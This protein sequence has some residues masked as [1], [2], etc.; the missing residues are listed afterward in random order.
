MNADN[1][2]HHEI[3]IKLDLGSFTN[4]LKLIGF[5]GQIDHEEKQINSFFDSE[6]RQLSKAGWALRIRAENNR[7]LVTI[8]SIPSEKGL[9]VVR[10]EIEAEIPRGQAL[11]VINLRQDVLGLQVMPVEFIRGKVGETALSRLVLFENTRQKKVFRIGDYNYLLEIDKTEYNDGSVDYELELELQ[12]TA[13]LQVIESSLMKLF[14]S[15]DIPFVHQTLS[16]FHRALEKAN[17]Y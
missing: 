6:D 13:N 5:L 7:G 4:Y 15:L 17:I 8:K 9:A 14:A 3:E 1:D 2:I 16:K 10:Q 12:D 11:D